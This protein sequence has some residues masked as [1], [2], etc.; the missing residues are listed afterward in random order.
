LLEV[1][2]STSSW[3]CGAFLPLWRNGELN[4]LGAPQAKTLKGFIN[5]KTHPKRC[6]KMERK[7]SYRQACREARKKAGKAAR[8]TIGK[9]IQ[10]GG[11]K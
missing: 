1:T 11:K 9:K 7:S 2:F 4:T 10:N 8:E 3:A 6:Q 5:V